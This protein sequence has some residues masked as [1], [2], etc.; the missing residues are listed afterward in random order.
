MILDDRRAV[1]VG[2]AA[3]VTC[4]F[5]REAVAREGD[6]VPRNLDM[7]AFC[8]LVVTSF[9][10]DTIEAHL[11]DA[12]LEHLGA[13][14]DR[15]FRLGTSATMSPGAADASVWPIEQQ[16]P[17]FALLGDTEAQVGVRL[18]DSLLMVPTKVR[19]GDPVPG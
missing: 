13:H 10:W 7:V 3:F 14:V 4:C 5:C 17:L 18:T 12:A 1:L 6:K 19:L 8:C 11:S 9:W 15:R 16:R 2:G